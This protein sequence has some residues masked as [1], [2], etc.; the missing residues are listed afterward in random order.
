M[1]DYNGRLILSGEDEIEL[2]T[3][4]Q[5]SSMVLATESG[6]FASGGD[7]EETEEARPRKMIGGTVGVGLSAWRNRQKR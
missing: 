7:T 1:A 6:Q 4:P 2:A 3:V 5:F